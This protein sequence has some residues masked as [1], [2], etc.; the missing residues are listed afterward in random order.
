MVLAIYDGFPI[1]QCT[2]RLSATAPI[3]ACA[4]AGMG[5]CCAPCDGTISRDG[6]AEVVEQVAIGALSTDV[7][8][9]VRGLSGPVAPAGRSA[10]VRGGGH[11][12]AAAGDAD[13]YRP[14]VPPGAQPGRLPRDRRRPQERRGLGDPRHPLRPAGRHR[15]GHAARRAAGGGPGR[16]GDRGDRAASRRIRC[17]RPASRR[18]SGSPTGWSSPACGSSTSSATGRGRCTRVLDQE[19]LIRHAAPAR[20][21]LSAT[22]R[23]S[24]G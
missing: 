15:G 5:R 17:R 1:R 2:P 14:P 6:Y 4:L 20:C 11:H 18:P 12:P 10:A 7:R 13:P 19:N 22:G 16:P 3:S 21:R 9:A 24:L 8:P 23:G